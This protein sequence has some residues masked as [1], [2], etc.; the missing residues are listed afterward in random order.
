[1]TINIRLELGQTSDA[2]TVEASAVQID[3]TTAT[4]KQV[5]DS[6]RI[7]ELP[8]NGR[9]AASL[10][11]LVA[12]SVI[13][14]SNNADEGV[15]KTFPV[16]V[17]VSTNGTRANQVS[18]QLD[19]V[20]NIDFLSNVNLPFPMPDALQEFSV[21]TNNY[22]AEFGQNVGGV[23]NIVTRSGTNDFHGDVFGYLRNAVF[24]SR[25]F[26]AAQRDPLK[27]SQYGGTVGGPMIR[28]KAFFFFGYQGTRIRS[29]QGGLSAF[30]PTDA[31][32]AGDFSTALSAANP[33]NPQQRAIAIK[34]PFTG[35]PFA[36]NL[37]PASRLDPASLALANKWLPRSGGTGLF[38][39]TLPIAQNLDE[40]TT[41]EDYNFSPTDRI[42]FRYFR[43]SFST[44][45]TLLSGD[46]LTYGDVVSY[47]FQDVALQETH[48]FS[49]NLL[50][51][52]RFGF[53]YESDKREPPPNSP[54]VSQFGVPI[55]QGSA[56]AIEGI[57]VTGFFNFGSFPPGKFPRA[58]FTW[59]DSL[60]YVRGRHTFAFGGSFERDRLNESTETNSNGV[61]SFS[62]DSTGSA[63]ADFMLGKLRTFTQGNG[64]VQANRYSLFSLF[65][66]DTFK[67]NSRLTVNYGLRW[68]P[69][70]PWHD[71]YHEAEVFFPDLY[72]KGVRSQVYPNAPPGEMFS[73]D[74]GVPVD[75]R[76]PSW[77]N[78]SARM[79]FAYDVFGDGKTSVRG[80]IGNFYD[81]RVPGFANNRQSQATPFSLAVTL[82]SP[83]GPFSNP[84][85]GTTNP[86]PAPLPPPHSLVFPA[87]VLVYSWSPNDRLGQITYNGNL[88]IE[89]QLAAN[90]LMRAAYVGSRA[91]HINVNVQLNPAV[92]IPGSAASTDARRVYQGFSSI[93]LASSAGNS[94]YHSMQLSAEKRL[95]HGFTVLVNYTWS[96]S[97]DNIPLGEDTVTPTVLSSSYV[98]HLPELANGNRFVKAM[99]GGWDLNGIVSAQSGGPITVLAG[100]DRSLTGIGYDKGVLA[101]STLYTSGA[102][103]NIAPCV[104]FLNASSFALPATGTFGNLAKGTLTGPGI[105][106]WDFST[107]K[108]FHI[109]ERYRVQFRGEFFNVLNHPNFNNPG[110]SISAAGFGT[111]RGARDPRIGQMAL[112]LYF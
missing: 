11:T 110:A 34:D 7:V 44:P 30:V 73:G 71:L 103:A 74:P 85:L 14:P 61:F 109:T 3:T 101:G 38:A 98:W 2:I 6:A 53:Y 70:L 39:Y 45:A 99:A 54:A 84:Y 104:N 22:S 112:K 79:G 107:A 91:N 25:N 18:Y 58:G 26:F 76:R 60:R 5:V 36:G 63:L 86:F 52:F 16:A 77:N 59:T 108:V 56:N 41:K 10:T 97:L 64:Y 42:S 106:N 66:Q 8:L 111:I 31:N 95:S 19:G 13:A 57:T 69:S 100:A 75:G 80:G 37:I 47:G 55:S 4:L 83:Q 24:N 96:K 87:P 72:A 20:P 105:V 67:V 88:T 102:C 33:N 89:R 21:Q 93:P 68:E 82:T 35:Q 28:D 40:F 29:Q 27:R 12:G 15:T 90:W 1:V 92:Y 50:N 32:L 62:G 48:I 23:V 49:P 81:S 94:W 78:Y 46:L 9:N 43:D 51:D 17:T 65:A